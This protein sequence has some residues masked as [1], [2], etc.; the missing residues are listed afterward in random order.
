VSAAEVA[1][2]RK[3]S[4]TD[5]DRPLVTGDTKKCDVDH[6]SWYHTRPLTQGLCPAIAQ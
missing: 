6:I 5:R 3:V 4:V 2:V 1:I